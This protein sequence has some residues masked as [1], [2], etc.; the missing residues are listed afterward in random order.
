M[1][2]SQLSFERCDY[3]TEINLDPMK[4]AI[5]DYA[6]GR[7]ANFSNKQFISWLSSLITTIESQ[8]EEIEKLRHRDRVVSLTNETLGRYVNE[9]K[10]QIISLKAITELAVK[11][12]ERLIKFLTDFRKRTPYAMYIEMIDEVLLTNIPHLQKGESHE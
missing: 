3:M 12:N 9:G 10:Y 1:K 11:E 6:D 5:Q 2:E 4:Q 8:K 7:C